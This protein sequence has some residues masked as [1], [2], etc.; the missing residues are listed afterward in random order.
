MPSPSASEAQR[1]ACKLVAAACSPK[2]HDQIRLIAEDAVW[3]FPLGP[4]V[5][6]RDLKG[7]ARIAEIMG[8]RWDTAE[9]AE[10]S[11]RIVDLEVLLFAD[12]SRAFNRFS[13]EIRIGTTVSVRAFAQLL[14]ARDGLLSELVEYG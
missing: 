1:L 7:R 2:R 6:T 12:P 13:L 9:R 3:S 4:E 14:R 11:I 5:E 8:P 10:L